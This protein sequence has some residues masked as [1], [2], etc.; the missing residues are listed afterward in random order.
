[1]SVLV[2]TGRG[3]EEARRFAALAR[4]PMRVE[5]A[6]AGGPSALPSVLTWLGARVRIPPAE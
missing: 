1:M 5:A 6:P 4:P 3:D 2:A